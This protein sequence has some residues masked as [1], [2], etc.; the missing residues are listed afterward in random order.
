MSPSK[1]IPLPLD[2]AA[3]ASV[4]RVLQR[5]WVTYAAVRG[6]VDQLVVDGRVRWRINAEI[7]AAFARSRTAAGSVPPAYRE[8]KGARTLFGVPVVETNGSPGRWGLT[9]EVGT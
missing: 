9:I 6:P 2:D 8:H 1:R 3:E 5:A 4:A 7:I